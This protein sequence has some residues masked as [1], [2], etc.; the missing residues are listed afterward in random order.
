MG[1]CPP[2][3]GDLTLDAAR[4]TGPPCEA[5]P[6]GITVEADADTDFEPDAALHVGPLRAVPVKPDAASG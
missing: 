4:P 2:E 1:T 6:D 3:D 5:T